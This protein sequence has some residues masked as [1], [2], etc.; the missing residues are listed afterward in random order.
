MN[1][2]ENA[3]IEYNRLIKEHEQASIKL[4]QIRDQEDEQRK[5]ID[6]IAEKRTTAYQRLM[7]AVNEI[8]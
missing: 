7:D 6:L 4:R 5:T 8:G 2:L 1:D 3:A